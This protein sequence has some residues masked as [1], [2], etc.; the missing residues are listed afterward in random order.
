MV[1]GNFLFQRHD[2]CVRGVYMGARGCA[3]AALFAWFMAACRPN[4]MQDL[5]HSGGCHS[6]WPLKRNA[7]IEG[8]GYHGRENLY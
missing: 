3:F 4:A 2:K 1:A 5:K 7:L 6:V 8:R